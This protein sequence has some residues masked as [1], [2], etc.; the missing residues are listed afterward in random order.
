MTAENVCR[1]ID[2]EFEQGL[3][4]FKK[5]ALQQTLDFDVKEKIFLKLLSIVERKQ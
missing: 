3:L 2:T 5:M 4:I 1:L